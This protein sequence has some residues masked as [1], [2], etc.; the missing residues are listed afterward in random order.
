MWHAPDEGPSLREGWYR[1]EFSEDQIE[2]MTAMSSSVAQAPLGDAVAPASGLMLPGGDQQVVEGDAGYA[3]RGTA[4]QVQANE[5]PHHMLRLASAVPKEGR[6]LVVEVHLPSRG[7][8]ELQLDT[9]ATLA[10]VKS[11]LLEFDPDRHEVRSPQYAFHGD[12]DFVVNA[13][14]RGHASLV[15]APKALARFI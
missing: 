6:P 15:V 9:A 3:S 2:A 12:D 1:E 5:F 14:V 7:V 10:D 8:Q 13:A 11:R 4:E